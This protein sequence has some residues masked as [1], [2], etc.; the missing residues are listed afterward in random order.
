MI[1][2]LIKTIAYTGVPFGV[3]MGL[4][5]TWRYGSDFGTPGGI[6]SGV[7]FGLAIAIFVEIQRKKMASNDNVF[8]GEKVIH[9]GP[10]N[11]FLNGEGRGGWLTLTSSHLA[12]RSHGSN[13]Q[14]QPYDLNVNEIIEAVPVLTLRILPN[15]LRI[16]TKKGDEQLFVVSKRK[17]WA[18]LINQQVNIN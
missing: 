14:N 13:V 18:S 16:S 2:R 15:G 12:F 6:V 3:F 5:F 7:F 4:F 17:Q 10:A 9:Q 8:E 11:H 1:R